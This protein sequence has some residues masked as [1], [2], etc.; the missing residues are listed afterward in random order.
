M[1]PGWVAA[2]VSAR[3]LTVQDVRAPK[4]VTSSSLAATVPPHTTRSHHSSAA[5]IVE[6]RTALAALAG[7]AGTAAGAAAA[8]GSASPCRGAAPRQAV[9]VHTCTRRQ[10]AVHTAHMTHHYGTH[11]H[12]AKQRQ[13]QAAACT[14]VGTRRAPCT[15]GC[16]RPGCRHG[17]PH[18]TSAQECGHGRSRL[19][20]CHT[21]ACT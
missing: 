15:P 4:Q 20:S 12:R 11:T 10:R 19:A 21:T 14:A 2:A 3:F 7:V 18:S 8:A 9:V 16:T 17:V 5:A 1:P 6:L 13:E